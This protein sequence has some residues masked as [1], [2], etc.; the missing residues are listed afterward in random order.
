MWVYIC[1]KIACTKHYAILKFL[2][3]GSAKAEVT[4]N[5]STTILPG[6]PISGSCVASGNA[7]STAPR[8][9]FIKVKLADKNNEGECNIGPLGSIQKIGHAHYQRNF[10]ITCDNGNNSVGIKC[11]TH[12]NTDVTQ[13]N[14]QGKVHA[15]L[16]D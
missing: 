14:V 11:F 8:Y 16:V 2:Y 12:V 10:T 3:I 9:S 1:A 7:Y 4:I 13:T 15:D 6:K 5:I